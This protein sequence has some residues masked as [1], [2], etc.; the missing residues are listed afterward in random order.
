MA[1][2]LRKFRAASPARLRRGQGAL[3]G[4]AL[5]LA[6]AAIATFPAVLPANAQEA[7][8]WSDLS[9]PRPR[10][11]VGVLLHDLDGYGGTESG[12][13]LA[14]E[15]R[16]APLTGAFWN[17]VF[18]P[19]PHIGVNLSDSG[20][21]DSLYA[22][23]TWTAGIGERGYV[24]VDFGG[25]VHDGKLKRADPGQAALGSRILFHEALEVG[26]RLDER[27]RLGL[28]IEHMSNAD[29]TAPNDGITDLG[30]VVSRGF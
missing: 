28:R 7:K 24:S 2:F 17:D 1:G 16:G 13:D 11:Q 15:L 27:W 18:S 4:C 30:F 23:L 8:A 14:I 26:F 10:L 21:T 20:G 3:A 19:R 9:E 25:A 22:G 6:A 12:L 29:L 5:S